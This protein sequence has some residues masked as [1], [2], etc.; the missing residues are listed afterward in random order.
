MIFVTVGA[1]MPFDR[2]IGAVDAWAKARGRGDVFAQIGTTELHPAHIAWTN[3]LDPGEFKARVEAARVVVA[4]AGMGS[5]ITSLQAGRPII[6]M[7]RRGALRETRNDHQVSTANYWREHGCVTAA[8]DEVQLVRCLDG[9]DSLG[10]APKISPEA[11][12]EMIDALR[13]FI[14]QPAVLGGGRQRRRPAA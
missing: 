5:I 13:R 12:G 6:V 8:D 1:Q 14:G 9:L 7:P 10:E 11:S 3:H 4:H 2:L